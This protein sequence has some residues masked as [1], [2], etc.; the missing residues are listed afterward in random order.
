MADVTLKECDIFTTLS[1]ENRGVRII[2]RQP[3][4]ADT[5][6][7]TFFDKTLDMSPRAIKRAKKFLVRATTPPTEAK[8]DA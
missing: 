2:F 1:K 3:S 5:P 6:E 7:V 8:A 4:G